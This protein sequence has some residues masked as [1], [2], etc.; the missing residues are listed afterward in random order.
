MSN[1]ES[2]RARQAERGTQPLV[3]PEPVS[4]IRAIPKEVFESSVQNTNGRDDEIA[5]DESLT[6]EL[7]LAAFRLA[8]S[9]TDAEVG[10]LHRRT[11]AFLYTTAVHQLDPNYHLCVGLSFWDPAVNMVLRNQPVMGCIDDGPEMMAVARRLEGA[12]P[13]RFVLVIP[14]VIGDCIE[15]IIELGR[16]DA[17]FSLGSTQRA[18]RT[19]EALVA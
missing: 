12:K 5:Q 17:P 4:A 18:K 7:L 2:A 8:V 15:A 14:V 10:L 6:Q 11:D 19:V 1:H 3:E 9:S 13:P 16:S